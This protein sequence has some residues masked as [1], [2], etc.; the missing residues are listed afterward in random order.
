MGEEFLQGGR[1][2]QWPQ[3]CATEEA[4]PGPQE[5]VC[6]RGAGGGGGVPAR[7]RRDPERVP[8]VEDVVEMSV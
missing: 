8:L 5:G 4:S 2:E 6:M 7:C 1:A 3:G